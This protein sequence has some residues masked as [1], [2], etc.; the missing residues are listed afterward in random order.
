MDNPQDAAELR[1]RELEAQLRA[2]E[3]ECSEIKQQRLSEL[4]SERCRERLEVAALN[5]RQRSEN[6][7]AW[8]CDELAGWFQEIRLDYY[9]EF[10]LTQE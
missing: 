2:K 7:D 3:R 8:S 5:R 10:I 6:M 1:I 4:Q 9:C